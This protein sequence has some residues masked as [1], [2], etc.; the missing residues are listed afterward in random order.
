MVHHHTLIITK[1]IFLVFGER[2]TDDIN[3][4]IGGVWK[5][6]IINLSK[7]KTIFCLSL[8]YDGDNSLLTEKILSV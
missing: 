8:Y 5:K 4:S 3:G 6:F 7:A 1:T 2:P